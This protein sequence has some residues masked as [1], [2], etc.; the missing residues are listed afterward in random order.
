[1]Y[2]ENLFPDANRKYHI[3]NFK[4]VLNLFISYKNYDIMTCTE[5][6]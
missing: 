6:L 2:Q 4:A 5:K 3:Y 1:M